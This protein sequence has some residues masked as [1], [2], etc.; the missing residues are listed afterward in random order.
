MPIP[1]KVLNF[2]EKAKINYQTVEH[3][4]VYTAFDKAAT[5]R[6]PEKVVGKTLLMRV[7]KAVAL[8]LIPANKNLDTPKLK[9]AAKAKKISFVKEA[10][11]KQNLTGIKIGATPP[12][13]NLWKL[14]TFVD[15]SL[16]QNPKIIVNS[17]DYNWSIKI[18]PNLLKKITPDLVIGSLSRSRT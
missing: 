8:V 7:D 3:R 15:K 2:L 18:H 16:L 5:L 13:G 1:K 6:V 14:V 10:W 11:I 9:K 17:G 4:T 12:W